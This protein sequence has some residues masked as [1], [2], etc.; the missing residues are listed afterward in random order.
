MVANSRGA[1]SS[2]ERERNRNVAVSA[3][4][5]VSRS[6]FV[7]DSSRKRNV[8]PRIRS[9]RCGQRVAYSS[10]ATREQRPFFFF[11]PPSPPFFSVSFLHEANERTGQTPLKSA[12]STLALLRDNFFDSFRISTNNIGDRDEES[13]NGE[14]SKAR[15]VETS[16]ENK[17]YAMR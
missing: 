12:T 15:K 6:P 5:R 8:T 11:S 4:V 1:Q 10:D 3:Y 16:G 2:R 7:R 9:V 17:R 14:R 13:R